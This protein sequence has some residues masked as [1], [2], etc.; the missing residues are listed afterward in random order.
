[1]ND[2]I[3]RFGA[4]PS[5]RR[6]HELTAAYWPTADSDPHASAVTTEFAG[7]GAP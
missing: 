6:V 5:G 1:M 3:R 4:L 2:T 7:N